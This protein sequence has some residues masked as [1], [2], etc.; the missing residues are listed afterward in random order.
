MKKVLFVTAISVIAFGL[1][2]SGALASSSSGNADLYAGQS[3][4][5]GSIPVNVGFVSS[6]DIIIGAP[7]LTGDWQV[8]ETHVAIATSMAGIPQNKSGNPIPGRFPYV[9]PQTVAK[10]SVAG[11]TPGYAGPWYI[12]VHV[13][14][15]NPCTCQTETAWARYCD[16]FGF[17]GANWATYTIL[18]SSVAPI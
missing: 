8:I 5:V 14:V 3:I 1:L 4:Y 6:P 10:A 11:Y 16:S 9:A 2:V 13:V 18:T 15:Y 7:A 12:A 17:P